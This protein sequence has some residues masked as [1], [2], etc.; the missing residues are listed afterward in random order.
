[1]PQ[2]AENAGGFFQ[3]QQTN[4]QLPAWLKKIIW[5]G[6][7]GDKPKGDFDSGCQHNNKPICY[8]LFSL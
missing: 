4:M 2:L 1:M 5:P 6:V 3:K 7:A 8:L